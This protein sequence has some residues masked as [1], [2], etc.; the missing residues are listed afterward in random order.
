MLQ[1][2]LGFYWNL[3]FTQ[4]SLAY[5]E[6]YSRSRPYFIP[7]L[8]PLTK[9]VNDQ[10]HLIFRQ[11]PNH[12]VQNRILPNRAA[13]SLPLLHLGS[14]PGLWRRFGPSVETAIFR[15]LLP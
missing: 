13:P 12:S 5:F 3:L 10:Q 11:T 8:Q 7:L 15:L 4:L 1:Y 6:H 14:G 9:R 2:M